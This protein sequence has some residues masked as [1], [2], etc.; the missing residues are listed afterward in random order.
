M[1]GSKIKMMIEKDMEA[2]SDL[3]ENLRKYINA[4][5]KLCK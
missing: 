4:L 2:N 1:N 5:R 3:Q